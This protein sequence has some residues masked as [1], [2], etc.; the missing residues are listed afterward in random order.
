MRVL[1]WIALGAVF[2]LVFAGC[3]TKITHPAVSG[4]AGVYHPR[5]H[6]SDCHSSADYYYYHYP[7]YYNWYY[8]YPYWR[9]YYCN[10]WWYDDYW[11]WEGDEGGGESIAPSRYWNARRGTSGV[12]E[13][14]PALP[15]SKTKDSQ[16][17]PAKKDSDIKEKK[18]EGSESQYYNRP[19]QRGQPEKKPKEVEKEEKKA[20]EK[21]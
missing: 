12:P 1:K 4:T 16:A 6:C 18:K 9:S 11:W 8:G 5:K 3:Y 19:T 21:D 20:K 7:Y 2:A 15:E 14:T 17:T 10:P 13:L